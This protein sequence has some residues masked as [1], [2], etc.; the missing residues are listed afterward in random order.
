MSFLLE[1]N[2]K[3]NLT[4]IRDRDEA[5]TRHV[6][7]SLAL[8]EVIERNMPEDMAQNL[9]VI[10]IGSGPGLPGCILAIARPEWTVRSLPRRQLPLHVAEAGSLSHVHANNSVTPP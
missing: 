3:Y 9:S 1:E 8:L 5:I 2:S 7:D 4:A 6:L 10:D